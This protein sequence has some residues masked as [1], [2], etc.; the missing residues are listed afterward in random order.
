MLAFKSVLF[1]ALSMGMVFADTQP[2][3][4]GLPN[5]QIENAAYPASVAAADVQYA[6]AG[7]ENEGYAAA[8]PSGQVNRNEIRIKRGNML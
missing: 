1:V 2:L 5:V 3:T 6:S 4:Q 8:I 7:E